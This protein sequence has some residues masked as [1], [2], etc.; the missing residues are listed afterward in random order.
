VLKKSLDPN[1]LPFRKV[2]AQ[3]E[4]FFAEF[5]ASW[6]WGQSLSVSLRIPRMDPWIREEG[7]IDISNRDVFGRTVGRRTEFIRSF[8]KGK[9]KA[10]DEN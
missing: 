2:Q 3:V 6:G 8:N 4:Q 10:R 9:I 5:D 7:D 1:S